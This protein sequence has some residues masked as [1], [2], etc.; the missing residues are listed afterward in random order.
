MPKNKIHLIFSALLVGALLLVAGCAPRVGSGEVDDLAGEGGTLIDMPALVIDFDADG[1]PSFGALPIVDL[2]NSLAPGALDSVRLDQG[3]LGMMMSNNIQH[4]Q[5]NNRT[6]GLMLLVNGVSVPSLRWDGDTLQATA[7]MAEMFGAGLPE[8][9]KLL[10]LVRHLGIAVVARFPTMDGVAAIPL[11][12]END[13]SGAAIQVRDQFL[14]SIGRQP[15]IRLPVVYNANGTFRISGL[16]DAEYMT[17]MPQ[18]PWSALRMSPNIL[19]RAADSG[20]STLNIETAP[21][22]ISI[23]LNGQMLP[24]LGWDQG[25]LQNLIEL[26]GTTGLWERLAENGTDPDAILPLIENLLPI[27]QATNVSLSVQFPQ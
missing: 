3:T 6:G 16:T 1:R 27:V 7:E 20:I 26:A 2:A 5:I 23:G 10:P 8:L 4:V 9:E 12:V 15:V 17:L 13:G 22:G 19:Q 24:H 14:A 21:E 18:I 11:L 25:E